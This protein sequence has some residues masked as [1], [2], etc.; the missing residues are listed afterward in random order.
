MKAFQ[1]TIQLQRGGGGAFLHYW[2]L[3]AYTLRL[4]VIGREC[5]K[6]SVSSFLLFQIPVF[7]TLSSLSLSH[8]T[9]FPSFP[10]PHSFSSFP[11][12]PPPLPSPPL[13]D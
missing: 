12:P 3:H 2:S 11:P 5:K 1:P 7:F 10:S 9:S 6:V 4:Y 13:A 8:L